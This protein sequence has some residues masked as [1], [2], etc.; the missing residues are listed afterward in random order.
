MSLGSGE[1]KTPGLQGVEKT[2]GRGYC[3]GGP[4]ESREPSVHLVH[5]HQA[6]FAKL[7]IGKE[8]FF[9]IAGTFPVP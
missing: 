6:N 7:F 4:E 1:Q 5:S 8:S 2:R 9:L 3:R